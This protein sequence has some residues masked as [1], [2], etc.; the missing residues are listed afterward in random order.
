MASLL[1]YMSHCFGWKSVV[2]YYF[3]PYVVSVSFAFVVG[4]PMFQVSGGEIEHDGRRSAISNVC[5]TIQSPSLS[6]AR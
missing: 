3:V 2:A 5:H 4:F 6:G 1:V